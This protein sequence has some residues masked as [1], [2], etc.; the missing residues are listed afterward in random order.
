[1]RPPTANPITQGKHG[2]FNAVDYSY[3]PDIYIYAPED[4]T[5]YAYLPNAGDAGNNLQITGKTGR[6]GFCHLEECYIKPGQ[7]GKKGDR[8]GKMGY[9][10][11]TIPKGPNGRH[12]H[13]V[14]LRNDTYVYPPT[15]ITE[16]FG[17]N[18]MT[19]AEATKIVDEMYWGLH[20]RKVDDGASKY[21]VDLFMAGKFKQVFKEVGD[22]PEVRKRF[23]KVTEITQPDPD[24]EE[25]RKLKQSLKRIL[26]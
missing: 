17:G 24:G 16:P 2:D 6:H 18:E 10:G 22:S 8:I 15:L 1:M 4:Y 19:V 9:T 11:L 26:A 14:I 13:W 21:F 7:S 12:L 3:Q 25:Y 23:E 20:N 5:F